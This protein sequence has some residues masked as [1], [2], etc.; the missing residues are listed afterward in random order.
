MKLMYLVVILSLIVSFRLNAQ[1]NEELFAE[2]NAHYANNEFEQAA[3]LYKSIIDNGYNSAEL[4][5]NLGNTYF[6]L[7]KI[8]SAILYYERALRLTPNDPD[9][10]F[11]LK[12]A[13]LRIVDKFEPVPKLFFIDWYEYI[14]GYLNSGTW[15]WVIVAFFWA[16]FIFL[17]LFMLSKSPLIKKVVFLFV[18]VSFLGA[19]ISFLITNHTYYKEK[20]VE[21]GIIFTTSIYVKSAPDDDSVDL[22]I[23]HEGTKVEIT[24]RLEG[25]AEILLPNGNKGWV[26]SGILEII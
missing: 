18:L 17:I 3:D 1:T 25:W 14:Q 23:L 2:A 5:Y 12:I 16:A 21:E 13:N 15:A 11:N 6:R 22:F 10:D 9:I 24:E 4:Y 7:N 8:P 19:L 26:P 20:N